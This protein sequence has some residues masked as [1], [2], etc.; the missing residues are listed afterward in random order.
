MRLVAAA[1]CL[2]AALACGCEPAELDWTRVEPPVSAPAFT[3]PALDGGE[4]R[5]DDARGEVVIMEFWATWCGPCRYTMPSLDLIH[6]RHRD[7]GLRVFLIN[8]G[9]DPDTVRKFVG[10]K[11]RTPVLLD[12]TRQVARRYGVSGIPRLFVIDQEGRVLYAE[13]GYEG[14]LERRLELVLDELLGEEGAPH[15]N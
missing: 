7:R 9:E 6:R 1:A 3:L 4:V 15:G 13:A 11:F 14:W 8:V 12:E 10:E 2:A 5:L